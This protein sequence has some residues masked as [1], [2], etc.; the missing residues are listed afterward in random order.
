M[1][2]CSAFMPRTALHRSGFALAAAV[3]LFA[4]TTLATPARATH[5]AYGEL[6]VDIFGVGTA[7]GTDY[8]PFGSAAF[9]VRR[10]R[11]CAASAQAGATRTQSPRSPQSSHQTRSLQKA[12]PPRAQTRALS[13]EAA[14]YYDPRSKAHQGGWQ[15]S[16]L[17]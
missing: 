14:V 9:A 4:L 12:S 7:V 15:V 17:R 8:E 5:L 6:S 3:V 10:Q 2:A 1:E 11:R 13:A 16:R